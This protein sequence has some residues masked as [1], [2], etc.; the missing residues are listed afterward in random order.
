LLFGKKIRPYLYVAGGA[1]GCYKTSVMLNLIC[2]LSSLGKRSLVFSLEDT[3]DMFRVKFIATKTGI[4]KDTIE[5]GDWT[6]DERVKIAKSIMSDK[7]TVYDGN[8]FIEDIIKSVSKEVRIK[9]PDMIFLDYLQLI[10]GRGNRTEQI[11]R[12]VNELMYL[13]KEHRIPILALSQV[14]DRQYKD[15]IQLHNGALKG[16]GAIEQNSAYVLLLQGATEGETR[17]AFISKNRFGSQSRREITFDG[18]SG[19]IKRVVFG[20]VKDNPFV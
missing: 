19:K 17:E 7:V 13:C 4:S 16:S 14:N 1:P 11:E 3:I 8:M 20:K 9:K 18:A 6:D 5:S 2:H 12:D 10:R 15:N